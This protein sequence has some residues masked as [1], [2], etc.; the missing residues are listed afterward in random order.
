AA[1]HGWTAE[2]IVGDLSALVHGACPAP[3]RTRH[4][5]FRSIGLGLEDVAIAHALYT[6]LTQA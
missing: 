6:Y 3:S 5:F 1:E 4:A 2:R